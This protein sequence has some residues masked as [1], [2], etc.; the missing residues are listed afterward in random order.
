MS[1]VGGG[2][3]RRRTVRSIWGWREEVIG[4]GGKPAPKD[5]GQ[6]IG[7]S[8]E[9]MLARERQISLRY[10]YLFIFLSEK[11]AFGHRN[12]EHIPQG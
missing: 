5:A 2:S 11:P 3:R 1:L 6:G 7:F 12:K 8:D 9:C 10:F 4:G